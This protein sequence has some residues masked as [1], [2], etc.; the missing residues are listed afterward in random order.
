MHKPF[1]NIIKK[2]MFNTVLILI[3]LHSFIP[4]RHADE[5]SKSEHSVFHQNSDSF[6][7]F[8]EN[9]FHEN[10]DSNLDN[11]IFLQ[12]E[13]NNFQFNHYFL[14]FNYYFENYNLTEKQLITSVFFKTKPFKNNY[15]LKSITLRGPPGLFFV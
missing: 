13:Q 5:M 15:L 6:I 2:S 1:Q 9:I 3:L 7:D 11:L 12:S 8:F 10:D 14:I 4:H